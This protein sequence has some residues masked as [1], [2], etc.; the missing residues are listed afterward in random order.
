MAALGYDANV[1]Q[2][3]VILLVSLLVLAS[4]RAAENAQ[5]SWSQSVTAETR[6]SAGARE[7]LRY[8]YTDEAPFA[9]EV[10]LVEHRADA[11]TAAAE[12][13]GVDSARAAFEAEV[14][15][16]W[17]W[18][19]RNA[20]E[21]FGDSLI[22]DEYAVPGAGF[23]VPARLAA[24]EAAG[25]AVLL[26]D[27]ED[28]ARAGDRASATAQWIALAIIPLV[29]VYLVAD[30]LL[31]RRSRRL[32]A[33]IPPG[34]DP[35]DDDI[36]QVPRPW[37]SA[38]EQRPMTIIALL[39]WVLV[40]L[41]PAA[42]VQAAAVAARA[43]SESSRIAIQALGALEGGLLYR[44]F[45]ADAAQQ[46]IGDDLNGV[47]REWAALDAPPELAEEEAVVTAAETGSREAVQDI[48]GS[49]TR[50][51]TEADGVSDRLAAYAASTSA[52]ANALVSDRAVLVDEA[53]DA[54]RR[55]ST[56]AIALL[57]GSLTLTL[58]GLA[59]TRTGRRLRFVRY[60]PAASLVAAVL[61]AIAAGVL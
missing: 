29:V 12:A 11:M 8:V 37:A 48:V 4:S 15:T 45:A 44:S 1:R 47:A 38:P 27:P 56:L 53:S 57:L 28:A 58:V 20:H 17:S 18:H 55:A 50:L 3:V 59:S 34:S 39:A 42:Q 43:G 54:Q 14:A 36:G 6:W 60:A 49:M 33:S 24:M 61:V 9:L 7:V 5:D 10:A 16:Q 2:V 23:D 31:V 19:L 25:S 52:D 51:P 41:L 32:A 13:A 30:L 21:K 40:A 22:S 35:A 26:D 46:Q